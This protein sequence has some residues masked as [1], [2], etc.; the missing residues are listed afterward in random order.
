MNKERGVAFS[1]CLCPRKARLSNDIDAI[2]LGFV[3]RIRDSRT[4]RE[5]PIHEMEREATPKFAMKLGIQMHLA[6]LSLS[7]TTSALEEL[8]VKRSRKAVHD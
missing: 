5:S 6:G 3:K 8:G 1:E 7:N 4:R 2:K